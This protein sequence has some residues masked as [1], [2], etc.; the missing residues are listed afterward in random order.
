MRN[1][2]VVSVKYNWFTSNEV[3]EEFQEH[4]LAPDTEKI[5]YHEPAGPGDQ[6]YCDIYMKDGSVKRVFNLNEINFDKS[7]S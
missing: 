2:K 1:R 3:G 6:H 7:E 5:E 4:G